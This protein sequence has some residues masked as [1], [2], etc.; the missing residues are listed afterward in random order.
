MT[1]ASRAWEDAEKW[2]GRGPLRYDLVMRQVR[3]VVVIGLLL[4]AGVG[5]A[6]PARRDARERVV[7]QLEAIRTGLRQT[8]YTHSTRIDPVRGIFEFDCSAMVAWVLRRAAPRAQR[9]VER[10]RATR[11]PLARDYHSHF[12]S[13]APARSWQRGL[14]VADAR[15]GDV[16]AWAFP[17]G[18]RLP[19]TGH[20]AI[21]V[22]TPRPVRG[23]PHHFTVRIADATTV[24]HHDDTRARGPI[25]GG[26]G[27]GNIEL[28][29]DP[30]THAPIAYRWSQ[31]PERGFQR[32]PM[33]MARP[34]N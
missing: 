17:P 13:G 19:I 16:L 4:A 18:L 31:H 7:A 25:R 1:C 8:R 9:E 28:R 30:D 2:S 32:A 20:V 34:L 33:A 11:R 22:A 10:V 6:Q 5:R 29:V 14:E 26:F 27:Y 12:A 3:W 24:P 23:R 21:V 15:P